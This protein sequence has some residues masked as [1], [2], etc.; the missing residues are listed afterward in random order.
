MLALAESSAW[1][2][3]IQLEVRFSTLIKSLRLDETLAADT[4]HRLQEVIE[5]QKVLELRVLE[6]RHQLQAQLSIE[7]KSS[8][9]SAKLDQTYL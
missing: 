6:A 5:S 2:Q 3:L 9:N 8:M 1:D 7:Q 4:R